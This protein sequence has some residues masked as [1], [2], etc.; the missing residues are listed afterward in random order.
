M[1]K[2]TKILVVLLLMGLVILMVLNAFDMGFGPPI[3]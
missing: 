2:F 1:A 3:D